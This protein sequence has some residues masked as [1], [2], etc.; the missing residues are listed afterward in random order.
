MIVIQSVGF[1]LVT[2][3]VIAFGAVGFTLQFGISNVFNLSFASVMALSA[4]VAYDVTAAGA[5]IWIALVIAGLVGAVASALLNHFV[6]V[7]FARRG[8][9]A[10]GMIVVTFAIA[11]IIEYGIVIIWGNGIVSYPVTGTSGITVGGMTF[12]DTELGI[13]GLACGSLLLI[14]LLLKYSK[15]GKAMRAVASD[16]SL[17]KSC[18][19]RTQMVVDLAW[20]ISGVLCGI[21]GVVIGMNSTSFT[22]YTFANFIVVILAAAVLGGV[23]QPYGAMLGALVI[24]LAMS[25]SALIVNPAYTDVVAFVML[26]VVLLVRPQGIAAG[27]FSKQEVSR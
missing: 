8:Q 6:Y 21:G 4:F 7:P 2:A 10:F 11:V 19:I 25:M 9:G 27:T 26:A 5:S 17:A 23:G 13:M 1:G 14:H 22:P 15:L 20:T 18:G 12:S 24:G 16:P 3:S